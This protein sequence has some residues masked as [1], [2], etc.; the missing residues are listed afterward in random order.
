MDWRLKPDYRQSA[1]RHHWVAD[2][3]A[4]H[5]IELW[6]GV[7]GGWL[8]TSSMTGGHCW[9]SNSPA[10]AAI[11]ILRMVASRCRDAEV[12]ARR[13]ERLAMGGG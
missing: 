3:G 2:L 9:I 13:L 12:I 10:D 6:R 8:G 5:E 4:G 11:G 7:G 1:V